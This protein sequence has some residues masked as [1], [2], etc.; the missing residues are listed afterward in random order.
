MKICVFDIETGPLP[1]EK[2]AELAPAFD[3]EKVKTGNLG[4]EKALAKVAAARENHLANILDKAAL[5]AVY[6]RTLACGFVWGDHDDPH[7]ERQNL[8]IPTDDD[9]GEAQLLRAIWHR[10]GE[11]RNERCL[12]VGHNSN[13]FD[14]PF[15]VRRSLVLG[16]QPLPEILPR[17]RYFPDFCVDLMEAWALGDFDP[18]KRIGLD[19]LARALGV[20]GK[21]GSGKFFSELLR[22]NPDAAAD[23]LDAD[24][25]AT[26]SVA[27]RILPLIRQN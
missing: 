2:V 20:P 26:W 16:V 4:L 18:S 23:Y 8:F 5:D 25:R 15:L 19:R 9:D 12:L 6:G 27:A 24:M 14:L 21:S 3:E 17:T 13:K 10:F 22:E 7:P 1:E 11:A